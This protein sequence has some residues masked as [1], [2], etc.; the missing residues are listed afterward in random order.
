MRV[1][2]DFTVLD[3]AYRL[4][5]KFGNHCLG[6]KVN[7]GMVNIDYPL[8][9]GD[10]VEVLTAS[11][12]QPR[13][14]WLSYVTSPQA[15]RA[16]R[17]YLIN[18]R[19]KDVERGKNMLEAFLREHEY[20]ISEVMPHMGSILNFPSVDDFYLAVLR[21]EVNLDEELIHKLLEL[22][23]KG[24]YGGEDRQLWLDSDETQ[25]PSVPLEDRKK[26]YTLTARDGRRNYIRALC[27][28]PIYGDEVDGLLN[29]KNQVEV[30]KKSCPNAIR[31]KASHGDKILA[32]SWG[33]HVHSNFGVTLEVE[34]VNQDGFVLNILNSIRE[35]HIPLI[36][37]EFSSS[38][39]RAIGKIRVRVPNLSELNY[40]IR[41][42]KEEND[43]LRI[44][45]INN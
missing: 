31:F 44:H 3:F 36:Q 42:L 40:L 30:H 10:Q 23:Q 38:I 1:P 18:N 37:I 29:D 8:H 39:D 34:G 19:R 2:Q 13:V 28:K 16:I 26:M 43:L 35:L 12:V 21:G 6:A 17:S 22:H 25:V 14:E 27:C 32:V 7:H 45:V 33:S 20:D 41:R 24:G 9:N 11:K 15:K 5:E 4:G